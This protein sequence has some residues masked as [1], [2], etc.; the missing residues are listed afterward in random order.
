[1]KGRLLATAV[2][3]ALALLTMCCAQADEYRDIYATSWGSAFESPTATTAFVNYGFS[4]NCNVVVPEIRLRCDAYYASSIE[5]PGT[6]VTPTPGY[7]S[8]ADLVTKTHAK[9][10]KVHP[11][12]VAFRIWTTTT[13]APH[14]TPEHIWW[15]HGH[16]NTDPSQDWQMYSDTGAWDYG[17]VSNLDPGHPAV[18]DYLITVFM[19]IVNRYDVDG[20][21]L[22]YI[23]YPS[24][25]YGYNPVAVARYNAEYGGTGNPGAGNTTWQNWRRDQVSN[26]VKRLYLEIKAVKPHVKLGA[27]VWYSASVGNNSYFQNW[28]WWMQNHWMDYVSPMMYTS[29]N[30]T[31]E[32][33]LHDA[34]SRQYGHHIYPLVDASNSITGNVLPQIDLVRT[35]GFSGM[36]LYAYQSIPDKT[37]LKNALIGGPFPTFVA[38]TP[39][40]WLDTP[41]KGYLKGFVKNSIGNA[42]YPVTVSILSTTFTTKNTGTG[43]Y[44]FS[45]VTPGAYTVRAE[46]Q[47]YNT[48]DTPVTITAGVVSGI[49]FTLVAET[50]PPVITN[51]RSANIQATN[52]QILWDTDEAA[53]SQVDYGQVIP[54]A[55]MTTEDMVR[56]TAHTVQLVNLAPLTTYH[57]RV[58]S[59]D[60]VRN[61]AQS[62]DYTFA[63]TASDTP[64]DI[65]VDN[66]D[67]G[68][69]TTG[70][71]I[72][73]TTSTDKYGTN[74]F[75][76]SG[77]T[78]T[79]TCTWR[80]NVIVA[81]NYNV[82]AWWPQG[83][84]R[85]THAP[86]TV[87]YNGGSQGY[88]ANQQT[89]G[90]KWNLMVS[91]KPFAVGTTGYI[92]LT[93]SGV[94]STLNVM[95]DAI[96]LQYADTTPPTDPTNLSATA[97]SAANISLSW[98]ASTDNIGV[99]GYEIYRNS[100]KVGTSPSNS[101]SDSV[102]AA[103]TQYSYYVRAYDG[104]NNF[105][106]PSNTTQ[107]YTLSAVPGS[108][109]VTCDKT[110]NTWQATPTFT[111]TAVGGFGA[112]KI[113]YYRYA[114]T[115]SASH[116]WTGYETQWSSGTLAP[117]A[118]SSG[119]WYLHV[120]GFNAENL[121]NGNYDYG[122]YKYDGTAVQLSNLNDGKYTDATGQLSATWNG[123]DPESGV[124][125]YKYAIGTTEGGI[126]VRDW[127]TNST[128]TSVTTTD[129]TLAADTK[130]YF[131]VKAVNGAGTWTDPL[132]S[133]GVTAATVVD[134]IANALNRDN[135][136]AVM[137][138]G[139]VVSANFGT[140]FYVCEDEEDQR[141]SAIRVEGASA[142][143]GDLVDVSGI[144]RKI[145]GERMLTD[146]DDSPESGPGA[147]DPIFMIGRDV[148]GPDLNDYT[149]GVTGGIGA[150]NI[151][152]LVTMIGGVQ[153]PGTG[154]F[155]LANGSVPIKVSTLMLTDIPGSG[156]VLRVT[157]IVSTEESGGVVTPIIIPRGNSDC[158]KPWY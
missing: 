29:D 39:M 89:N 88:S 12:V 68:C 16:G 102:L 62:T 124:V 4:C 152:T 158:P 69:T 35:H 85:T 113:Q 17:G 32:G 9:S 100:V 64:A 13:G 129:L 74:Y 91:N 149:P 126:E 96:R 26:L 76:T 139:K 155:M 57:Y 31:Y 86:Y 51:V 135:E 14:T 71:W 58:R 134:T 125:E 15:T 8:L 60:A 137:L 1:M 142:I 131:S 63:T 97:T 44:G 147:P 114:W 67:T 130:Y 21:L 66:S 56:V 136:K 138:S 119:S 22:D 38:P 116:S 132:N 80:P 49:D 72:T 78:Q 34:M 18:E 30:G 93:N 40:S 143:E 70:S 5:P 81:G 121:E 79:K 28:D 141:N 157:G 153:D 42:I 27:S 19:D 127:T 24:T 37:G 122:P 145:N 11:W 75:Y 10:M 151:G 25:S 59:Y 98:T 105:S 156:T 144:I 128:S 110:V 3:A 90:G 148:G 33:Y 115:Q 106:G 7:D 140:F 112:G 99:V 53:T 36:G 104:Q 54:Y 61:M 52:A 101:F 46:A 84:N 48:V 20:L 154:Y 41:T 82:Y 123:A 117:Q 55:N 133:D 118:T 111:F 65:I 50:T 92:Q 108:G 95:A 47:G 6:G 120:K 150:Y 87:Y 43:F 45:E 77:A 73:Q 109:S 94:E 83:G 2:L 107:R 103:N 23:R 146:P